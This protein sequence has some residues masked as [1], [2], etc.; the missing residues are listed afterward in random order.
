MS[1]SIDDVKKWTADNRE[2]LTAD[3]T[4]CEDETVKRMLRLLPDIFVP[5]WDAGCWLKE[6]LIE[7]GCSEDQAEDTCFAMGQ[8]CFGG[9]PFQV[10]VKYANEWMD[11]GEIADKP[12]IQLACE[13][14]AEM[15]EGK[16]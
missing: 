11:R 16:S 3:M 8:R 1:V 14:N 10:A 4:A 5:M 15:F 9:D 13:I 6:F 7:N 12:G 2:K